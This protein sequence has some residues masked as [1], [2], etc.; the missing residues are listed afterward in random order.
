[1]QS[2]SIDWSKAV[3]KF[4]RTCACVWVGNRRVKAYRVAGS[5]AAGHHAMLC[6]YRARQDAERA[7]WGAK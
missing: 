1:M 5:A 6:A 4:E 2:E 3:R 7:A